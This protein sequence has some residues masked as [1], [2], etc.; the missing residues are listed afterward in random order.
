MSAIETINR[1]I[2]VS[3]YK[4]AMRELYSIV[5]QIS[6]RKIFETL[7]YRN[8]LFSIDSGCGLS[9]CLENMAALV[10][11][12]GIAS[13]DL[14]EETLPADLRRYSHTNYGASSFK[15]ECIDISAWMNRVHMPE[16]KS[17]LHGYQKTADRTIYVFRIP[18]VEEDDFRR[19]HDAIS[20]VMFIQDIRFPVMTAQEME[21]YAQIEAGGLGFTFDC[22]A[23][24]VFEGRIREEK[25]DGKF[26]GFNTIKKVVQE[27]VFAKLLSNAENK[28]GGSVITDADLAF[29]KDEKRKSA[30]DMLD[31]LIG[32]DGVKKQVLEITEQIKYLHSRKGMK[33]PCI[34]MCFVGN[35]GTGKTT[36][37]RIVGEILT[38][39]G[40]LRN[41]G[42][43]EHKGR[44]FVGSV[45]GETSVKTG[46]ICRLA[47]G[48]VLF[49]DEAYT[50]YLSENDDK[51][52]GR[53]ALACLIAEM[54]N[55]RSDM[56]VIMAGYPDE[57]KTLMRG[58]QGLE[59]R[60]PYVIDFENYSR[61][62]LCE[63]FM[64]RAEEEFEVAEDLE[65]CVGEYFSSLSDDYLNSKG[66]G[67]AR[68]VRNLYERT[69]KNTLNRCLKNGIDKISILGEDFIR[70]TYDKEFSDA[71]KKD[72][73][74]IG[75]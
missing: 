46:E 72:K 8:Y 4:A 43:F 50:L 15:I 12:A 74:P 33:M 66:F 34:H 47:Y 65:K 16:F 27:I 63:I 23:W 20:D 25:R 9:S 57:M 7:F 31:E 22:N 10:K 19:I 75:F 54:E 45:I 68:F 37:A 32:L 42:F 55:H 17:L 51:D 58:N 69:Q 44:D 70:A 59:S 61:E 18:L 36:V 6:E 64:K 48:S 73:A 29:D 13:L 49:I 11:E 30:I 60:M 24:S 62:Q 53:E 26:Y 71:K 39:C 40:V 67:N 1:M 14:T 52:F 38:E 21:S 28:G 2:G 35:S 56:V 5:P 3:E 41:G